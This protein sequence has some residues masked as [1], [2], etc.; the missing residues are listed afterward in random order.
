MDCW[1]GTT[2]IFVAAQNGHKDIVL[3]LI[4]AEA[5][6]NLA[7]NNGETPQSIAA[8]KGHKDIASILQSAKMHPQKSKS[9]TAALFLIS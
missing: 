8:S 2:R 5:N 1:D 9:F 3:L 6:V 4:Y 7:T